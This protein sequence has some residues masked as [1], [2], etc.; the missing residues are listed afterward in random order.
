M[1]GVIRK[2]YHPTSGGAVTTLQDPSLQELYPIVATT[3]VISPEGAF[4]AN[5]S[6]DQ[7][8]NWLNS[9]KQDTLVSGTNIKTINGQS[10]LGSGDIPIQGGGGGGG[11]IL[12]QYLGFDAENGAVY[13]KNNYGFYSNSF[14]SAGGV[15]EGGTPSPG[16]SGN[17]TSIMGYPIIVDSTHPLDGNAMLKFNKDDA[18]NPY[19]EPVHPYRPVDIKKS[20]SSIVHVLDGYNVGTLFLQEGTGITITKDTVT[21][22][23]IIISSTGGGGSLPRNGDGL[24]YGTGSSSD[25]LSVKYGSGLGIN[26]SGQLYCTINTSNFVDSSTLASTLGNYVDK[27]STQNDITGFKTFQGGIGIGSSSKTI[28]LV[29]GEIVING[30]VKVNG[31]FYAT[32]AVTAGA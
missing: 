8:I 23:S 14:I 11:S 30:N 9:N 15:G 1:A 2:L 12:D 4:H 27:T 19:W 3:G 10:I 32:G 21:P 26:G 24:Q 7:I 16:G 31:N 22:G 25:V 5:D 18:L 17:A 20:D 28:T 13:V 6:L 29:N